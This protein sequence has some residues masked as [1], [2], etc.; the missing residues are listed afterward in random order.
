MLKYQLL[1]EHLSIPA[2]VKEI[3]RSSFKKCELLTKIT[4]P[5]GVVKIDSKAF[6]GCSELKT[7]TVKSTQIKSV[8]KN[9][10]SGI[11]EDAKLKYP[12][13]K[14]KLYLKLF[15]KKKVKTTKK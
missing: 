1:L 8:A 10:F 2:T 3:G 7:I 14:K 12:K 13:S 11:S 5:S 6:S 15:E 4:I 9:A